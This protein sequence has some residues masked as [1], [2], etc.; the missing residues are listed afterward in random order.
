MDKV[1]YRH[2]ALARIF[3]VPEFDKHLSA[4]LCY[5]FLIN[6]NQLLR[7]E[8]LITRLFGLI[9]NSPVFGESLFFKDNMSQLRKSF[10][11]SFNNESILNVLSSMNNF[12]LDRLFRHMKNLIAIF[13]E[14]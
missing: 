5:V 10:E 11:V 9:I 2:R 14:E 7:D 6:T 4:G 12:Q 1:R 13:K 3:A 8:E